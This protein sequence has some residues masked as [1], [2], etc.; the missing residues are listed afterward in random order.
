MS[1]VARLRRAVVSYCAETCVH[2]PSYFLRS[3]NKLELGF[4]TIAVL[5]VA[6]VGLYLVGEAMDTWVKDPLE[7]VISKDPVPVTNVPY[8]TVTICV[9]QVTFVY[10]F[11]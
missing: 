2:G 6:I 3:R 7:L 1:P 5:F 8:P 4:W 10:L 9:D 11:P